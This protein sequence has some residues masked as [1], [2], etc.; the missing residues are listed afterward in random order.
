MVPSM[1]TI[2]FQAEILQHEDMDAGFV[3]IPDDIAA[4]LGAKH[5]TKVKAKFDGVEY[6][7]SLARMKSECLLLGVRK[8]IRNQIGKQ[9]GEIIEVQIELDT[10]QRIVEIPDDVL[11]VFITFPKAKEKFDKL[12]YTHQKEFINSINEAKKPETR[13]KRIQKMIEML[14]KK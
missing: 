11:A 8:E 9:F 12:S 2:Q 4:Q 1:I 3:A 5:R 13:I 7:G 10:E 6:R 14:D